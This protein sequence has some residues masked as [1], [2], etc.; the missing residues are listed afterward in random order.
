MDLAVLLRAGGLVAGP[1]AVL[2]FASFVVAM[3]TV[4]ESAL[5]TAPLAIASSALLLVAAL[6][7]AA[8]AVGVLGRLREE[9]V[10]TGG[11]AVAAVG[12]ALVV[13]GVWATLF[14]MHPLAAEVPA[15]METEI[16]GIVI[17]YVASYLVFTVG[18]VWTGIALLRARAQ[19]TWAG[20]LLIVAG[21]LASVPSPEP[22][23]MLLIAIAA[24]LAA[25]R[26]AA[27]AGAVVREPVAA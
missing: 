13:G 26:L 12:S 21:V 2:A 19:P 16:A 27:P 5:E 15:A 6:G 18:W 22:A 10:A 14:V 25:R 1:A 7:I 3:V 8:V 4:E 9:G 24:S 17:G 11:P 23:R 20:V